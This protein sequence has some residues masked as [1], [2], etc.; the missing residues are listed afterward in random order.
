[1]YSFAPSDDSA[2]KLN[3][4]QIIPGLFLKAHQ[5][6]AE[7]VKPG[8]A[9]FDHPPASYEIRIAFYFQLFFASW[10]NMR[11]ISVFLDSVFG[12]DISGV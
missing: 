7:S 5:K 12:T 8:V 9:N 1:M 4:T 10:S 3:K 6:L 2:G 11:D